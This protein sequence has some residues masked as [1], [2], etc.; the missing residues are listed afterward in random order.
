[1]P[2]SGH[3][4]PNAHRA[5]DRVALN[6]TLSCLAGCGIGELLDLVIGAALSASL[7]FLLGYALTLN[8]LRRGGL[9]LR[10]ALGLALAAD[11]LSTAI[12]EV[13]HAGITLTISGAMH[14]GPQSVLFWAGLAGSLLVAAL[15]AY[16]ANRWLLARAQ[17]HAAQT[18][19]PPQQHE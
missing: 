11:A 15:A 8:S 19:S 6:A 10:H 4:T 13:A 9:A 12:M 5:A 17:R 3:R 18:T 2:F 7:G 16:P 14:V 1:M